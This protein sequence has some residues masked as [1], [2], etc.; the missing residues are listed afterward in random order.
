[1]RLP[2]SVLWQF[3]SPKMWFHCTSTAKTWQRRKLSSICP[4]CSCKWRSQT[5][6]CSGRG[7]IHCIWTTQWRALWLE[8]AARKLLNADQTVK[9]SRTTRNPKN[10]MMVRFRSKLLFC[11]IWTSSI[12]KSNLIQYWPLMW[13]CGNHE[14]EG[15]IPG[16]KK[17]ILLEWTQF[18]M[19]FAVTKENFYENL[20]QSFPF[21]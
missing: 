3:P 19:Y 17:T 4:S 1:M 18:P 16:I 10:I 9:S 5:W 20:S 13:N 8:P 21:L 2:Q 15:W 6:N 12:W 11:Y 14:S 7:N